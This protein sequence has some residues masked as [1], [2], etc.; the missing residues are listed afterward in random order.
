MTRGVKCKYEPSL[1]MLMSSV[2]PYP[3]PRTLADMVWDHHFGEPLRRAQ[4]W[5]RSRSW[6]A[7]L[8]SNRLARIE[9]KEYRRRMRQFDMDYWGFTQAD[10]DYFQWLLDKVGYTVVNNLMQGSLSSSA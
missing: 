5:F 4:R 7:L 10:D 3:G 8:W 2:P 9:D 1:A 6:R